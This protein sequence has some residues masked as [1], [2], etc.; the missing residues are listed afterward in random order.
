MNVVD[1][2]NSKVE[3]DF[4]N[5]PILIGRVP[6]TD[7]MVCGNQ[8]SHASWTTWQY[9]SNP[10]AKLYEAMLVGQDKQSTQF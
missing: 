4:L 6:F 5:S 3:Q 2:P 10:S 7:V 8:G 1:M 9:Q